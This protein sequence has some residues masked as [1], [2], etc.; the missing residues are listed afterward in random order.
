VRIGSFS[1]VIMVGVELGRGS[2]DGRGGCGSWGGAGSAAARR[3]GSLWLVGKSL[4]LVSGGG[5]G[6]P[7]LDGKRGAGG[8]MPRRSVPAT[9]HRWDAVN[10]AKPGAPER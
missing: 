3:V 1:F 10:T 5:V 8:V 6:F 2:C 9:G 7:G 4:G